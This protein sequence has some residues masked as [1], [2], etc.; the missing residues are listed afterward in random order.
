MLALALLLVGAAAPADVPIN[1]FDALAA[2]REAANIPVGSR[3]DA[4]CFADVPRGQKSAS[5]CPAAGAGIFFGAEH[6]PPTR[7]LPRAYFGV[8]DASRVLF[9]AFGAA[10]VAAA[11]ASGA[12]LVT[13][14]EFLAMIEEAK[15]LAAAQQQEQEAE[16]DAA[17]ARL[18]PDEL[19]QPLTPSAALLRQAQ[20]AL[21]QA[22]LSPQDRQTRG[23]LL[24]NLGQTLAQNGEA[25]FAEALQ[26]AI[27]T[28]PFPP[29]ID[30]LSA[31][32]ADQPPTTATDVS[33]AALQRFK[34]EQL[35]AAAQQ[36]GSAT[37]DRHRAQ[38]LG[39][40]GQLRAATTVAQLF[41]AL[42]NAPAASAPAPQNATL[43]AETAQRLRAVEAAIQRWQWALPPATLNQIY[44]LLARARAAPDPLPAI[45]AIEQL[46]A[47]S[48]LFP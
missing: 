1:R 30:A 38:L 36:L 34:R 11:D 12:A 8:E 47:T 9:R 3:G 45:Q 29:F 10:P 28:W 6:Q 22:I 46:L 40:I 23:Q 16:D 18:I 4:P 14:S 39:F 7:L 2:L 19:P 15:T 41:E 20:T 24:A 43:G 25:A 33:D 21:E 27:I 13:R 31:A 5:I 35:R 48:A 42:E 44:A 26:Q 32:A 17:P 37:T